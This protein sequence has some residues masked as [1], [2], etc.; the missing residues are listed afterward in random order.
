M[1]PSEPH[2]RSRGYL[3]ALAATIAWSSSGIFIAYLTGRFDVPPLA[4][5]FWRNLII[6]GS[7][8]AGL[9]LWASRFLRLSRRHIPVLLVFGAALAVLNATYPPSVAHNGAAVATVLIYSAPLFSAV[10]GRVLLRESLGPLKAAAV[11]IGIAGCVLVSGAYDPAHWRG[12]PVGIALGLG[13]GLSFAAYGLLGRVVARRGIPTW[14]AMAY[15]FLLSTVLM[16]TLLRRSAFDWLPTSLLAG[17]GGSQPAVLGWATLLALALGPTLGGHGLYNASLAYLP[18]STATL[19]AT[20]EPPLTA[21]LA[22]L[23]LGER[24]GFP[25]LAG[26]GLVLAGV[27]AVS[28]EDRRERRSGPG[29]G[30]LG[31]VKCPTESNGCTAMA[32]TRERR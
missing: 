21:L 30:R 14:T 24:L 31:T 13:T 27:V 15:G 28:I 19:I 16:L 29:R 2:A 22:Y 3:I 5:A 8:F 1:D 12:N 11:A 17:A 20:L 25:Q 32:D 7:V 6:T 23:L 26:S 9:G 18:A 10:A 4:V